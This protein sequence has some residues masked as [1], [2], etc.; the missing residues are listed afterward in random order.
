VL[1]SSTVPSTL[2]PA[3]PFVHITK[4]LHVVS[5]STIEQGQLP[6]NV[7]VTKLFLAS[8]VQKIKQEFISVKSLGSG[9]MEEWLKGLEPRGQ[10]RL[11]EARKWE[12]WANTGSLQQVRQVTDPYALS[13]N[14]TSQRTTSMAISKT[15]KLQRLQLSTGH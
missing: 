5:L 6:A 12:K 13:G 4:E 7:Q 2:I 10:A 15:G 1:L 3:L 9:P 11:S 14:I 8:D